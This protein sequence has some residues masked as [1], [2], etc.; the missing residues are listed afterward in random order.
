VS[1]ETAQEEE[2][3]VAPD[4]SHFAAPAIRLVDHAFRVIGGYGT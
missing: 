2:K 4:A 3:N 1:R